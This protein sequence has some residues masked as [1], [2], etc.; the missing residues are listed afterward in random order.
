MTAEFPVQMKKIDIVFSRHL[1]YHRKPCFTSGKQTVI[2]TN[3]ESAQTNK[4]GKKHL[5]QHWEK[6]SIINKH[7]TFTCDGTD[8]GGSIRMDGS[9]SPGGR[10][11]AALKNSSNPANKSTRDLAL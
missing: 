9:H 8:A 5:E 2:P 4:K 10:T 1:K 7:Y 11:V 6:R 3:K